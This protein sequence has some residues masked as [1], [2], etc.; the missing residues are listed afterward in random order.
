MIYIDDSI[1][2]KGCITSAGSKILSNFTAPFDATVVTRLNQKCE[3]VKLA[4]FGMEDPGDLPGTPLLCNDVF[5]HVRCRA[6]QQGLCYIRP[7]YGTVS[8]FGLIPTASSM[9]QIGIVCKNP[10]EGFALLGTIAGHDANDGAMFPEKSYVYKAAEKNIKTEKLENCNVKHAELCEQ[11]MQILS[12]AEI[13]NNISR[14]DGIKFG[15]RASN[16]KN[17][18]ELYKKTRTE[19]FGPEAKLAAIMGCLILSEDYYTAYYEKAMKIRRLIKESLD[20]EKYDVIELPCGHHLAELAGLPSLALSHNGSCIQIAS[21][22]K[23][24]NLLIKA[25]EAMQS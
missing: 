18:D 4:E 24:E 20:F 25:W 17:L 21:D 19:A 13:S 6:V 12:L 15:Y 10:V 1:M 3:S 2:Q 8:R 23:Q 14:Y 22:V 5:G 9:D 11:V 16:Y 7:T